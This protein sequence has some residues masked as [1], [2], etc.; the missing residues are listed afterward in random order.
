[1]TTAGYGNTA[2]G[3]AAMSLNTTGYYNTALG[4]CALQ[5]TT[6][7]YGNNAFGTNALNQNTTGVGNQAMGFGA[8]QYNTTGSYNVAI[9]YRAM[10]GPVGLAPVGD[11]CNAVGLYALYSSFRA[12]YNNGFGYRALYNATTGGY[13]TAMGSDALYGSTTGTGNTAFGYAALNNVRATSG[14]IA[15]FS[16]YSATVAGT[17]KATCSVAHGLTGTSTKVITGTTDYNGSVTITVIDATSFYFT[18]TFTTTQLGWWGASGEGSNNTAVG[19]NTG[20]GITTGSGNTIIGASVTGLSPT[21]TN[22]IILASGTAIRAKFDGTDWSITSTTASTTYTT[23]CLKLAGGLGV[24][25]AI[26]TSGVVYSTGLTSTGPVSGTTG[27]FSGTIFAQGGVINVSATIQPSIGLYKGGVIRSALIVASVDSM[28]KIQS[29]N[30][31]GS[32]IDEAIAIDNITNGTITL[33]S[34]RPVSTGP[35]T[36]VGRTNTAGEKVKRNPQSIA[37]TILVTDYYVVYTGTGGH[38]FTLPSAATATAGAVLLIKHNGSGVLTIQR[39]GSDTIDGAVSITPAVKQSVM[40]I[41]DGVS[42]WEVN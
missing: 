22:N 17:V 40:L 20:L 9:G 34:T 1:M 10:Y 21:L 13:N 7:G 25:G 32:L 6:A 12:V 31:S 19:Y 37:Y 35:L 29:Y 41:S 8:L 27:T 28:T 38:A 4:Y 36:S 24:S 14:A 42:N 39:G 26:N 23:G 5:M 15:S 2:L 11:Y 16:D 30:S 33:A 18:D 3:H